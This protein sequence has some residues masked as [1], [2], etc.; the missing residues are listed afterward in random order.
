MVGVIYIY[1][2]PTK[3]R[4][5]T[6]P[7]TPQYRDA[8]IESNL[9]LSDR[10]GELEKALQK[11]E[12]E[13]NADA[14]EHEHEI[15][16]LKEDKKRMIA[17]S[18]VRAAE[19]VRLQQSVE[20]LEKQIETMKL[21][22]ATICKEMIEAKAEIRRLYDW[23]IPPPSRPKV[24]KMPKDVEDAKVAAMESDIKLVYNKEVN[25]EIVGQT[26]AELPSDAEHAVSM[27]VKKDVKKR[28]VKKAMGGQE[29][30]VLEYSVAKSPGVECGKCDKAG[31]ES[32]KNTE[33]IEECTRLG[34]KGVKKLPKKGI[35]E[36][37]LAHYNG[38]GGDGKG[39]VIGL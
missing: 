8:V 38:G 25:A 14:C 17:H 35:V 12:S 19:M 15:A 16:I 18:T 34:I 26:Q 37:L 27:S 9:R 28:V 30:E 7:P 20:Q 22:S 29:V 11:I 10:C 5:N 24:N 13:K 39:N 4:N 2:M 1:T 33:L 32:M 3:N 23:G 21:N 6:T 36:R 31:W